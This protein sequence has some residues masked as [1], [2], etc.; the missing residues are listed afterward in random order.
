MSVSSTSLHA[1]LNEVAP[2]LQPRQVQVA[3]VFEHEPERD[4]SN[5]EIAKRLG[6]EINQITGRTNGLRK[7]GI[8]VFSQKRPCRIT[9]RIVEAYKLSMA[10]PV[11]IKALGMKPTFMQVPS[12]SQSNKTQTVKITGE[13]VV[14]GCKGF[15]FKQQCSHVAKVLSKIEAPRPEEQMNSLFV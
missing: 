15:Y 5:N 11:S 14:C 13:K 4:F 10:A 8:L 12:R 9:G 1:Y 6:L 2:T 3:E 7:L